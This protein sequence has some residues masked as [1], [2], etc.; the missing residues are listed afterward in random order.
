MPALYGFDV[1][2]GLLPQ[3]Y[4]FIMI[5]LVEAFEPGQYIV[6]RKNI[7]GNEWFI[8]GHFPDK[9]I[10]PGAL[11]IE[12]MAQA[13]ILFFKL[14]KEMPSEWSSATFLLTAV[15]TRFLKVVV[16]GDQLKIRCEPEKLIS[17]AGIVK[18][19]ATVEDEVV[20]KAEMTFY[21]NPS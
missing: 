7:T 13:G 16:P 12:G 6:C 20:A 3:S 17:T 5:D 11:I 14:N 8:P 10:F 4:P 2:R 1:I 15:K 9:A 21:V 19:V 18:C